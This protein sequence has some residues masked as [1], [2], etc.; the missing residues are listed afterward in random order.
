M[1]VKDKWMYFWATSQILMDHKYGKSNRSF[2]TIQ[3]ET[4]KAT[5]IQIGPK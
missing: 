2:S 3:A 4:F 1:I 5:K